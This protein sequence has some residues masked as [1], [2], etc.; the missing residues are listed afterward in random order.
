MT[1][2]QGDLAL[3]EDPVAQRLLQSRLRPGWPTRDRRHAPGG[4]D[5]VP[6]ERQG[7]GAG[8]AAGRPQDEGAGGRDYGG[9][10]HRHDDAAV[11][12]AADPRHGAD[13]VVEGIAPEYEA[14]TIRN[15]GEEQGRAWLESLRRCPHGWRG[16]SSPRGG[17]PSSTSRA[18]SPAPWSA[19]WKTPGWPAELQS[20]P[21]RPAP[22]G[23]AGKAAVRRT[24]GTGGAP[25]AGPRSGN[26]S[27]PWDHCCSR[28]DWAVVNDSVRCL[29]HLG[30]EAPA[31]WTSA[32]SSTKAAYG[33]PVAPQPVA[34]LRGEQR[35]LTSSPGTTVARTRRLRAP[36][37]WCRPRVPP[38][39]RH[40]RRAHPGGAVL[41]RPAF[42]RITLGGA[43][44]GG[45]TLGGASF[46][47]ATPGGAS[48]GDD[49]GGRVGTSAGRLLWVP[50]RH[51]GPMCSPRSTGRPRPMLTGP[52]RLAAGAGRSCLLHIVRALRVEQAREQG[53]GSGPSPRAGPP[54]R[55]RPGRCPGSAAAAR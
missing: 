7:S 1:T 54:C 51:P 19:R 55:L 10:V 20:Q 47:G 3:L 44:P 14:M 43:A 25:D 21:R 6:L 26:T 8:H 39:S 5:R 38:S 40:H 37:R 32:G 30:R 31:R 36:G 27:S 48:F 46:G 13:D 50:R 34:L 28:R 24:T 29:N 42:G 16:S 45:A 49:P 22:C 33:T 9:P 15:L 12:G 23:V 17:S 4:A 52:R 41:G 18:A 11:Q 53:P 2:H 35:R